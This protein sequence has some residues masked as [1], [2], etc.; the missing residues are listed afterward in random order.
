MAWLVDCWHSFRKEGVGRVTG[1]PL[2]ASACDSTLIPHSLRIQG[3]ARIYR[4]V[5]IK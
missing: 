5:E 2:Q 3:G 4:L 1:C